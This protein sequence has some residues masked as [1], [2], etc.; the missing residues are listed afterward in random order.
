MKSLV[1]TF[2][3]LCVY[4]SHAQNRTIT[5]QNHLW[6]VYTGTFN[7]YK[8]L[9]LFTEYQFR[10]A[11][12]GKN[13]QQS[14]PRIGLEIKF[15]PEFQVTAGYG[16]I[17]TYPYGE[18]PVAYVFNEHRAWEQFN[19]MYSI[20][21]FKFQHR[22]RLEQRWLELKSLNTT[23]NEYEF[24]RYNYLNRFR[25]RF[26]AN[27]TIK[28]FE[29]SKIDLFALVIDELFI[30][31]GKNVDKNIFDQNRI[32]GGFGLNFNNKISVSLGYMNQFIFKANG[33]NAES[34]HTIQLGLTL[35]L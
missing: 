19:L 10:R 33:I 6:M 16:Y 12:L 11:D 2:F 15:K 23:N 7:L 31:F 26:M 21:K 25:Y 13:W 27:Y 20:G 5:N 9:N 1:I 8:K 14:L 35:S 24:L 22:Y 17:T 3:V 29:E 18:Q 28:R 34:N 30:A 4:L 32:Y